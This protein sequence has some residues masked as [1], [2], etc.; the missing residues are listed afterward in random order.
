MNVSRPSLHGPSE[1]TLSRALRTPGHFQPGLPG[2][3]G[4]SPALR[5]VTIFTSCLRGLASQTA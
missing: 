1:G 3:V 4:E 2:R 5:M